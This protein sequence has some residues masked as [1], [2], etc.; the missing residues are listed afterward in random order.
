RI[1]RGAGDHGCPVRVRLDARGRAAD[2]LDA[3]WRKGLRHE[4]SPGAPLAR[5]RISETF[6]HKSAKSTGFSTKSTAGSH[7]GS[8][9]LLLKPSGNDWLTAVSRMTGSSP[10][11]FR[12]DRAVSNPALSFS[13]NM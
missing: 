7:V 5:A 10:N 1:R 11:V 13:G 2:V 8:R 3:D 9:S 6:A 4:G 12:M